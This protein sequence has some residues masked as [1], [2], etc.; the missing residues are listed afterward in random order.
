M[1]SL[2]FYEYVWSRYVLVGRD[3]KVRTWT[4][5]SSTALFSVPQF[6]RIRMFTTV[7]G[8]IVQRDYEVPSLSVHNNTR[9]KVV[10]QA[11]S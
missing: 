4:S 7:R 9:L 10:A 5:S 2:A 8:G 1:V 3:G 11:G 6:T